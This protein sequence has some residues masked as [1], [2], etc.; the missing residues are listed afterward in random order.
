[1][2]CFIKQAVRFFLF[3]NV[4]FTINIPIEIQ[5]PSIVEINKRPARATFFNFETKQLARSNELSESR[6]FQSLNGTWKF[7]WVR[8]PSKRAKDFFKLDF[9]DRKWDKI[10]VP[11]NWELNGY[12]VPIYLNHPYEFSFNP[13]PPN[14]PE[15]YNTVG[16]YRR[17]FIIPQ[18]WD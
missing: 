17:E 2:I 16:S 7:N 1:M 6:F 14:I 13:N 4:V 10:E 15:E 5:D 9:D 11:S 18:N 3:M 8:D 12:G